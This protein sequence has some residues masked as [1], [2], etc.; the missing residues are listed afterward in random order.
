MKKLISLVFLSLLS[1]LFTVCGSKTDAP[2][3]STTTSTHT[4]TLTYSKFGWVIS[5][6]EGS[7]IKESGLNADEASLFGGSIYWGTAEN[8]KP[9]VTL[10][11]LK[12]SRVDFKTYNVHAA[13]RSS[14]YSLVSQDGQATNIAYIDDISPL[15]NDLIAG[16]QVRYRTFVFYFFGR[17][18]KGSVTVF[19]CPESVFAL[20]VISETDPLKH[21]E[22]L[23]KTFYCPTI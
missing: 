15:V 4:S 7:N 11:W 9:A 8:N 17:E 22:S 6:P 5:I 23:L 12:D 2:L 10:S 20:Q 16:Y 3:T 13:T 1:L 19:G 18:Y 14:I 21:I